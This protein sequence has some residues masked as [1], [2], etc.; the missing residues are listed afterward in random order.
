[1][2]LSTSFKAIMQAILHLSVNLSQ[3]TEAHVDKTQIMMLSC[4][5]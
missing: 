4:K 1:M 5:A 3:N 2:H